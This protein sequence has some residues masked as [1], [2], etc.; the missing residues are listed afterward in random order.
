MRAFFYRFAASVSGLL[1]FLGISFLYTH[2]DTN[3]Y[4][5]ILTLYGATPFKFPFLD[6]SAWLAVWECARHGV[7]VIIA[8]PC[9]VL[10]RSYSCSPL[11]IAA[12]TIPLGVRDTAVV[13]WILDLI[14]LVSLSL[15][16]PPRCFR[17]LILVLAATLSTMVVFALERANPDVLLFIMAL[18]TGVLAE[19][20]LFIRLLGYFVAL[21]AALL[22]YYPIMV[23]VIVFRERISIFI[24]IVAVIIGSLVSFWI[25]YHVD[26]ARGLPNVAQGPYVSG[27]FGAKNLP[28]L[29][30][31][32]AWSAAE[33]SG[34]P[35]LV[36]GIVAGGLYAILVGVSVTICR[37]LLSFGELRA[38]L[39]SLAPLERIF[40]VMGS[41]V[42]SGC[43]FAGQSIGYRGVYFLFVMPGLLA[44]SRHP[45]S[46]DLRRVG[47]GTGVVIVL[48]MWGEFFR[49]GLKRALDYSGAPD[50]LAVY[51]GFLLWLVRELGWWW[52]VSVLLTVVADFLWASP[53]MRW[54]SS[55]S[56]HSVLVVR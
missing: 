10:Q 36:Q 44:I 38:A 8:N 2:G 12:S 50:M 56:R 22:K 39:G 54:V 11:W 52:T 17:E 49:L 20:R 51:L 34:W 31:E 18:T 13:G 42:I 46:R 1:L 30:G 23:L 27:F 5:G 48:L 29:L 25:E 3:L 6:I 47:L 55:R 14:L 37:R 24:S 45:A 28:F 9:D 21:V 40:L 19:C 53:I 16:P 35:P 32:I 43:F 41:A 33:P 26:I 15:L 4:E 7:D